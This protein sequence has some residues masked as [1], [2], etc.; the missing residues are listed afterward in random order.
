[1]FIYKTILMSCLKEPVIWVVAVDIIL[2][3]NSSE[4]Q[5]GAFS[6]AEA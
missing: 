4:T 5:R 2:P 6:E 3:L 1:M